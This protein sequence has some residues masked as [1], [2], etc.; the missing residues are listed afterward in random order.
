MYLYVMITH[1][2]LFAYVYGHVI[3]VGSHMFESRHTDHHVDIVFN[4]SCV[5][6]ITR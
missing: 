6:M 4:F 5:F 1:Y 3:C 2:V